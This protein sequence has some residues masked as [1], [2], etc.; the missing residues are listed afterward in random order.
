LCFLLLLLLP[1]CEWPEILYRQINGNRHIASWM[2]PLIIFCNGNRTMNIRHWH[3][4]EFHVVNI[5]IF[6][7]L[8]FPPRSRRPNAFFLFRLICSF[9]YGLSKL[10]IRSELQRSSCHFLHPGPLTYATVVISLFYP[11]NKSNWCVIGLLLFNILPEKQYRK[12]CMDECFCNG[13][14]LS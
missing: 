3:G 8:P 14:R 4:T 5:N 13:H 9:H 1:I 11:S 10:W 12:S 7:T 6:E 2:K